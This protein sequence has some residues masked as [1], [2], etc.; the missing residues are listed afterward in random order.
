MSYISAIK[1]RD[2]VIVWERTDEGRVTKLFPAPYYFY[3]K[4]PSGTYTSMF[5]DKLVR[6]DFETAAEMYQAKGQCEGSQI[7]MFESDIPA[8]LRVLSE[9]YYDVPAPD[10]NV[11]FLDIE[12]DYKPEI[13]FSSTS[14]PY[15]EINSVAL[16]HAWLNKHVLLIVPP[17]TY[18]G[19][20]EVE[21]FRAKLAEVEPL[22]ENSD[23]EIVFCENETD[24]LFNLIIEMEHSDVLSGWNSEIFDM[25]YIGK[26]IEL[27]LG[28][29][30]FKMMSFPEAGAP[31]WKMT[32][33]KFGTE[34]ET[35]HINGRIHVD[36]MELFRKYEAAER[37]S[38]KLETISEE[39]LPEM[40]KLEYTGTL[41]TLYR[42]DFVHFV[43]YNLRDTEILRGFE[44]RLGYVQLANEMYHLS[45]GLMKHVTGTIKLAEL[46]TTNFCH[47]VQ[48]VIV[49]DLHV[50]ETAGGIDGAYVLLPTVGMHEW[51]GS[52]D[53]NS[54]YP[55]AIR[56]VNISPET[57][58]GQFDDKTRAQEEIYKKSYSSL[59]FVYENGMEEELTADEWNQKLRENKWSISGYGTVFDQAQKGIVP[60]ILEDWYAKR[61]EFQKKKGE[62]LAAGQ[63]D[64][65]AYYD[66]I[67]YVYK[68]K[69]NSFYGA[70]TNAYFRY[71]DSR[72]GESTTGTGRAILRHMCAQ[73]CKELDGEYVLPDRM[74]IRKE[75][76]HWGY[77]EKW[78]VAYGDTDSTYFKTHAQS[79]EEAILIA[80]TVASKVSKSFQTL[81]S[82][83]FLCTEGFNDLILAG[84][85]IV[86]SR[87]LFVD[88]KRYVLHIVDDEGEKVDKLK[89]MGLD[90]KKTTLPAEISKRLN[91][92]VERLLKGEEWDSIAGDIVDFKSELTTTEDVMSIGLPKGIKGIEEYT[93]LLKVYGDKQRLPGHVAAAVFYNQC[94]EQYEDKENLPITSGMKIKVF[95]LTKKYGRFK[96]IA[97]PTDTNQVPEW[98]LE[99]FTID[100]GLHVERLVDNPLQNI[101]KSVGYEVPSKQ[102]LLVDSLLEF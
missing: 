23:L 72:M 100:R 32:P 31:T 74:E 37:A 21:E 97:L 14:N 92:F 19:T 25:P 15:A 71:N 54:L 77:D 4:D 80:D 63:K 70:L 62:A 76:E 11:T 30:Y 89:V 38:Y 56:A 16:H 39:I 26:R 86:S 51:I 98:F 10:L 17:P 99:Q 82:D 65:A 61:K 68:I 43:R 41:A 29:K 84:R 5:G 96:S 102:T 73:V 48:D 2:E 28:A 12:V 13:G 79:E 91:K 45:T 52:M 85:E 55:S 42:D 69:L 53:I 66:R 101:I 87:G 36:Y 9:E 95:Y 24:L 75:K 40:R 94:L 34:A 27:V 7:E 64:E 78:S 3:T 90:T 33:T 20:T 22:D 59:N 18:T 8:D 49:P 44:D 81:M 47:Y 35:L 1:K 93:N 57:I 88:K 46:A 58:I 67:Q 50:D 60:S 83:Q 6:H